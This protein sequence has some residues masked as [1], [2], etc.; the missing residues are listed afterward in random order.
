MSFIE[1]TTMCAVVE[2]GK[3]LMINRE[4]SW[5]GW[6]FPGGHLEY[7]ESVSACVKRELREEAGIVLQSL[8]FKGLVNIYNTKT[9][10]R[11]LVFNYVSNSYSGEIMNE[12]DEGKLSWVDVTEIN[13]LPLA[14]GMEY[15]LPLFFEARKQELYV[16]WN[17][18]DGYT[19]VMYLEV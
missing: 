14:E 11:H 12:C 13:N 8:S 2:K 17:E 1:L 15:R 6:A 16:E 19:Q 4:K 18:K 7:G 5:K 3:V 10:K 9:H